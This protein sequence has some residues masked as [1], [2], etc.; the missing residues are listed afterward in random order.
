[1]SNISA[2]SQT[3]SSN[4]AAPPNG[5]PEGQAPSTVNDCA[6]EMMAG[7][8]RW[9]AHMDGS[10]ESTGSSNAYVITTGSSHAAMADIGLL[11]FR[12]NHTNTTAATLAVDGLAAK[13]IR[14]RGAEL[15]ASDIA[16][17]VPVAVV[18]NVTDD[19]FDMLSMSSSVAASGIPRVTRT[20]NTIL[21]SAN[22]GRF[23]DVTSG[24]FTQTLD[25]AATI[26][27]DWFVYYRN[28]GTGVVTIDP[29]SAETI[30]GA[31]TYII[32][33]GDYALIQCDGSSFFT[34][35][36]GTGK[37]YLRTIT[38]AA[39]SVVDVGPF[40]S[41][42]D[43]YIVEA[44]GVTMSGSQR[45]FARYEVAGV[46]IST[47][48]YRSHCMEPTSGSASYVGVDY[49]AS[50]LMQVTPQ[51]GVSGFCDFETVIKRPSDTANRKGIY[52]RGVCENGAGANVTFVS[53]GSNDATGAVTDLRF[54]G[55][56]DISGKFHVYGLKT[57]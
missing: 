27:A 20:S 46:F 47:A 7:M 29:D 31:A 12:A 4:N 35:S 56:A 23:I 52:S 21:T 54:Q 18:Y 38:A 33:P 3:A 40:D 6:R 15:A 24:T 48:T 1:M 8:A 30:D 17:D 39:A 55:S 32:G 45:I 42:Y 5:W 43:I 19:A 26:G 11:V 36:K 37:I 2:Y 50:T 34:A 13:A 9:Y 14:L 28:S 25:P 44:V 41:A 22:L 16:E 49:T 53:S 10:L 51:I 57:R